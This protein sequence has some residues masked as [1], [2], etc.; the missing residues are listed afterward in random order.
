MFG[1]IL[2][3]LLNI[4][5][6]LF[7]AALIVR[8]WL[9]ATRAHPHHPLV[10][11][12]AQVTN[13]LV[14]PL[15]RVI[16]GFAGIDWASLVGAWLAAVV[17]VLL[18]VLLAGFNLISA[19]PASLGI[20]FLI[21]LKW[22]LNLVV[23]ITLIQVILS[24]VNPYAPLMPVL[25]TLT[26]PLLNPIRRVLPTLGG[27]DFSPLVLLIAAQIGLMMV[28]RTSFNLFGF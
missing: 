12:I 22:I 20:A 7:G 9:Q 1:D 17:Y 6:T 3:F 2:R 26:A 21:M 28:A 11:G 19:L 18:M 16:P 23:W 8:A 27:F 15:R 10:R 14:H 25:H 13:W 5:F 4:G 24:W